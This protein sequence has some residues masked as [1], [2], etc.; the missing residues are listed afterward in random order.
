M[1]WQMSYQITAIRNNKIKIHWANKR[2]Q[3][4]V[5]TQCN[6]F[7]LLAI[8]YISFIVYTNILWY[9]QTI[10][11]IIFDSEQYRRLLRIIEKVLVV[12]QKDIILIHTYFK[13]L[14]TKLKAVGSHWSQHE[15]AST[16]FSPKTTRMRTFVR[17][18]RLRV[19]KARKPND[20]ISK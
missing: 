11:F 10:L 1:K 19:R 14:K 20:A 4:S 13:F 18:H 5:N 3:L 12:L 7:N 2:A 16:S 15:R 6:T 8:I 9:N 17:C